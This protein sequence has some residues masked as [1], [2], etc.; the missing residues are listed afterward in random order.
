[1][2]IVT[3]GKKLPVIVELVGN[4][5]FSAQVAKAVLK[6]ALASY[7]I[8]D[9]KLFLIGTSTSAKVAPA[10]AKL[11]F[12]VNNEEAKYNDQGRLGNF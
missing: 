9:V 3:K 1:M 6:T 4:D 8:N 12:K 11:G 2:G 7:G 10:L 5:G